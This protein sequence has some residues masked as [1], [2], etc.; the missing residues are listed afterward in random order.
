M[1]TVTVGGKQYNVPFFKGRI[2]RAS[3][4]IGRIYKQVSEEANYLPNDEEYDAIAAW[5]CMAFDNQFSPDE[6]WDGYAVDDL[7]K[8]AFALYL[9]MMNLNTKVLTVFPIP[10]TIPTPKKPK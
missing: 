9:A 10:A 8:D 3:G 7:I 5:F 4:E 2:Q 1:H 6:L